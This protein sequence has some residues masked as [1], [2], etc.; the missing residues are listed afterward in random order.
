VRLIV[1]DRVHRG[2]A[3]LRNVGGTVAMVALGCLAGCGDDQAGTGGG[4]GEDPT[5]SVATTVAA[6][7][8]ASTGSTGAG[9]SGGACVG[10]LDLDVDA[11]VSCLQAS[12]CEEVESCTEG[13]TEQ[14]A[15]IDCLIR[16]NGDPRCNDLIKCSLAND[17]NA[18][19][20]PVCDSN[21]VQG[22]DF[23]P[24]EL[25]ACLADSCCEE[26]NLCTGD[27]E[28]P[29]SCNA[30]FVAGGGPL[31]D[32]FIACAAG[33]CDHS[34][35]MVCDSGN[36]YLDRPAT[37]ACLSEACCE[38]YTA[39]TG[40][41]TER[42]A[43]LEC[44]NAGGG[45]Q[46]GAAVGCL[47]QNCEE[48]FAPVCN[49]G[50]G[51]QNPTERS[52]VYFACV[53]DACCDE[54]NTCTGNA[55]DIQECIACLQQG[56]GE[57]CDAALQCEARASC[58]P[59]TSY[60]CDSGVGFIFAAPDLEELAA[61]VSRNCCGEANEC[62]EDGL[63][64][65][66]CGTC[67]MEGGGDQCD[68]LDACALDSCGLGVALHPICDS[69]LGHP[70]PVRAACASESCCDEHVA[71]LG[72]TDEDFLACLECIDAGG[73]DLCDAAVTCMEESC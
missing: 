21:I 54:F 4:G 22:I 41:G 44:L 49:S 7:S 28:D 32:A 70:D 47:L 24:E 10:E 60:F 57:T 67:L 42:Q 36:L 1:D 27:G 18:T 6:T 65:Q 56:G 9:G 64:V 26:A 71:C 73:G 20:R 30:C 3:S 12:C 55:E 72:D 43:C 23:M 17:C 50:L 63:D 39:C 48:N 58:D 29:S 40:N 8:V 25:T 38:E 62:T 66:G 37:A 14:Q 69:G 59:D 13:G 34:I 46:C 45:K 5:T 2:E 11:L 33:E 15:C 31:C 16:W 51:Q 19:T 61:C 52:E 68:A 35:A 53:S